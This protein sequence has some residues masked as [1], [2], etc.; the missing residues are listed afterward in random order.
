MARASAKTRF[1]A[2]ISEVEN[3]GIRRVAE[4]NETSANFVVRVAIRRFL[5]LPV[6]PSQML[7]VTTETTTR[8]S[9]Q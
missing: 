8:E 4:E 2:Y 9:D 6:S 1:T 5:D 3:D 7:H